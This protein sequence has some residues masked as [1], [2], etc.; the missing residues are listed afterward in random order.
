MISR[1]VKVQLAF[2]VVITLVGCTFVGARYARLDR[3]VTDQSYTVVAHFE[4]SGGIFTGAEVT[5]RGVSVGRVG[6]LTLTDEGVDVELEIDNEHEDIPQDLEAVVAN[7]SAVG[8]Q[9]VDLQPRGDSG[10]FLD[11]GS[12]IALADTS[13]PLATTTLLVDIDEL[14]TSVDEDS[15]RTTIDELGAAFEGGAGRDLGTI[16]DTGNA[17]IEEADA[18]FAITTQLIRESET[19]LDTQIDS[20]GDIRTFARNLALFS[21]TLA[22]SDGDLRGV[23]DNG[24]GAATALR[25][26]IDDN[27]DELASLIG[28]L[29]TTNEIVVARLDGVEQVLVLYPYVVEGG[30]T[31]IA[32]DPYSGLYD[33]HFGLVLTSE[34]HVCSEGYEGT[35]KRPPADTSEEPLN[36]YA[37]C[38]AAQAESNA[39][40]A[41]NAPANNRAPVVAA[42][43][44]DTGRLRPARHSPD[45]R[46]V[47]AGGEAP[48]LGDDSWQWLLLGPLVRR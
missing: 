7:R 40:G 4:E 42:Y 21:D 48:V 18:N 36:R 41:Q 5:Y 9:Y 25:R 8:E 38:V 10:P 2:F 22:A 31:V 1:K 27:A 44:P 17:F 12:Q 13:V 46:V 19:V 24:S 16:I 37:R 29:T 47:A 45:R 14:V 15:L 33:A 23:I 20:R 26:L 6:P 32:K 35:D 39:R 28:N 11:D 30:Y 34:P 3:L 43:D